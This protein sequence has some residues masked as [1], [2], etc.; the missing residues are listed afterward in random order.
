MWAIAHDAQ[1]VGH[2]LSPDHGKFFLFICF[3]LY[4]RTFFIAFIQREKQEE[5]EREGNIDVRE[6]H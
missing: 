4:P 2:T 3:S 1:P 5:R 6:K